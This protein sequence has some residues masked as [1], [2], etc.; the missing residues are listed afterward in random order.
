MGLSLACQLFTLLVLL[1]WMIISKDLLYFSVL[2]PGLVQWILVV[3]LFLWLRSRGR[4]ASVKGVLTLSFLG[5][6][7]NAI[8][9]ALIMARN[10]KWRGTQTQRAF[11]L[12]TPPLLF[13]TP[14]RNWNVPL[15]TLAA[16][17]AFALCAVAATADPAAIRK[18]AGTVTRDLAVQSKLPTDSGAA[19][20]STDYS[21]DRGWYWGDSI[22][23]PAVAAVI[24]LLQ[25]AFITAVV[26]AIVAILAIWLREPSESRLPAA[27]APAGPYL[28]TPPPPVDPHAL[29]ARA[30][31]LA[32]AGQYAEAMHYVLLAATAMLGRGQPGK[33]DSLTSWELL[34]AAKLAPPQRSALRDLVLRV[35]RAWF[36][37]RPAVLDDYQ[38]VRGCFQAFVSA[39]ETA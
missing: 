31:Q 38:Q 33:S 13:F 12:L 35:E 4:K 19:E 37:K 27:L 10:S 29:L 23:A 20:P 39:P 30:D 14:M 2:L 34:R 24:N 15:R 9:V 18:T 22:D 32:A 16:A 6:L 21:S 36:G 26:V 8:F 25:W 17:L 11:E 28:E 1:V 5:V 7:L 3:P